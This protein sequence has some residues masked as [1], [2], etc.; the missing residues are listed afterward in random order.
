MATKR[1]ISSYGGAN[2]APQRQYL[3]SHPVK[4]KARVN[5][6][7]RVAVEQNIDQSV[8]LP[9]PF[10]RQR[11]LI[12]RQH[13]SQVFG[14][15]VNCDHPRLQRNIRPQEGATTI[16]P[17]DQDWICIRRPWWDRRAEIAAASKECR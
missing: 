17:T 10:T 6:S 15:A 11:L 12:R 3:D 8:C 7:L 2:E 5:A 1:R 4:K 9:R 13:R 14:R 16:Q